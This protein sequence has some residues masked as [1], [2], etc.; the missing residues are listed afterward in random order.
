LKAVT[1]QDS[2]LALVEFSPLTGRTHQI[3]IHAARSLGTP[4]AGDTKYGG[5][6]ALT[7]AWPRK[8]LCLHSAETSFELFGKSYCIE[9]PVPA[10]MIK[11]KCVL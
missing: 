6:T 10:Y 11:H 1:D 3:R 8:I 4:I 9:A 2:A 7:S 5:K